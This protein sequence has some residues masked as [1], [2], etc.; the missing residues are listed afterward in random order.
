MATQVVTG[1]L[2]AAPGANYAHG[3]LINLPNGVVLE[4][5]TLTAGNG[6]ISTTIVNPG[7]ITA[8]PPA[9]PVAQVSS[10]GAGTG[11][12]F[13]LTWAV[14]PTGDLPVGPLK[15]G[16]IATDNAHNVWALTAAGPV[17]VTTLAGISPVAADDGAE[18]LANPTSPVG[19]LK[20][21][22]MALDNAHN[23]WALTAAGAIFVITLSGITPVAIEAPQP[24]Y[25]D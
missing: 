15:T 9:N 23:V 7:S 24:A 14:E 10:N 1:S 8:A 3:D 17:F 5:V 22:S 19:P 6:V 11:A 16:N 21:G 18:P 2:V 25:D 4:V 12:T 20:T 13:N